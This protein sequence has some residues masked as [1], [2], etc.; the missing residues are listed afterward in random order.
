M[1]DRVSEQS[2]QQ[3][4]GNPRKDPLGFGGGKLNLGEEFRKK[5]YDRLAGGKWRDYISLLVCRKGYSILHQTMSYL[6]S[7]V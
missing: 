1:Q 4:A 3:G 5:L 7:H 6:T 2:F